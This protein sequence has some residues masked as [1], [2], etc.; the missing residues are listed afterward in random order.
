MIDAGNALNK[1]GENLLQL[2]GI[3]CLWHR[4]HAV[5]GD[6]VCFLAALQNNCCQL[7]GTELQ[8]L[9]QLGRQIS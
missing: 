7:R 9:V 2:R 1:S 6:L 8:Q 4:K 5:Q 3:G